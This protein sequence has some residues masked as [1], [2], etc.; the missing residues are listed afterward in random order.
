[1]EDEMLKRWRA[2]AAAAGT[3][4]FPFALAHAAERHDD[5]LECTRYHNS[6]HRDRARIDWQNDE[7][8]EWLRG[9][10]ENLLNAAQSQVEQSAHDG[11]PGCLDSEPAAEIAPVDGNVSTTPFGS[12][13]VSVETSHPV[14]D[15][16]DDPDCPSNSPEFRAT[17]EPND[18]QVETSSTEISFEPLDE[19]TPA[20]DDDCN[21]DKTCPC[22]DA[23]VLETPQSLDDNDC[24][25]IVPDATMDAIEVIDVLAPYFI[26]EPVQVDATATTPPIAT[27][28]SDQPAAGAVEL[29]TIDELNECAEP[30]PAGPRAE[31]TGTIEFFEDE[32]FS[33]GSESI[34]PDGVFDEYD[35]SDEPAAKTSAATEPSSEPSTEPNATPRD[36]SGVNPMTRFHMFFPGF[37]WSQYMPTADAD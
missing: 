5:S 12:D 33:F 4:L 14:T 15:T 3:L 8:P 13:E 20:R 31:L 9:Y 24:E 11:Q 35:F 26:D 2:L 25:Q 28:P 7:Q 34:G 29:R 22:Y 19:T 36:S 1:M 21:D 6:N 10:L 18:N 30:T 23:V 32:E 37:D 27:E 16:C 17:D